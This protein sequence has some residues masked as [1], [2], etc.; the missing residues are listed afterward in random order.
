METMKKIIAA[1]TVCIAI[2]LSGCGVTNAV[3]S[4]TPIDADA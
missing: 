4:E 1:I 2:T 3:T